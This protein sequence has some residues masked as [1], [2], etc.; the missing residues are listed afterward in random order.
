M[1]RRLLLI[2]VCCVTGEPA[3]AESAPTPN[4]AG[5]AGWN[6]AYVGLNYGIGWGRSHWKK[7]TGALT[8]SGM[9]DFPAD[10][11][12]A[13]VL[14]GLTL[15]YNLQVGDSWVI[16]VEGDVDAATLNGDADCGNATRGYGW[17]CRSGI[18]A[19]AA[20]N[21]RIGFSFGPSLLFL[22]G[23]L[24]YARENVSVFAFNPMA[25]TSP[26]PSVGAARNRFGGT[27]GVGI[28][29]A[30]GDDVSLKLE[31]DH[32]RFGSRS[33]SGVDPSWG[34]GY[35]ASADTNISTVRVG[36]NY[37]FGSHPDPS[38][39]S[40]TLDDDISGE[41]GA[42]IGW[43][44]GDYRYD[45][46][47][48]IQ[49]SR[50]NSR[51]TWPGSGVSTEVFARLDHASGAYLKGF[52]GGLLLPDGAKMFDEDFL[53]EPEEYSNTAI[54]R[55]DGGGVYAT[56]DA[57]YAFR[58]EAWRVGPFAG[59]GYFEENQRGYGCTQ[60]A[61]NSSICSRPEETPQMVAGDQLIL[62]RRA[63]WNSLR[64]GVAGDVMLTDRLRF[65]AEAAWV[66]LTSIDG[67]MDNHWARPDINPLREKRGV[68]DG[69]QLE[70]TLSYF[71]TDRV[72][73]G[74]G[75]RR[76]HM[77][78]RGS[79]RFPDVPPSPIHVVTDR[80]MVFGQIAYRFGKAG[81][82]RGDD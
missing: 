49:N 58:G 53:P 73:V 71:L 29:R 17:V 13:G 25:Y 11:E 59:Y 39:S 42:R 9:S 10:G 76:W 28:E 75:A 48:E 20:L 55:K 40:F 74:F 3:F 81:A 60:V 2:A 4:A 56:I 21:A 66:P 33:L 51:L 24:A 43:A 38:E 14:S 63:V 44:S 69:F 30:M 72:S 1:W 36:L 32:Y 27:V 23:G 54:I 62:S 70:A 15:G 41:F 80:T 8:A 77:S 45:L 47:D 52:V 16:G 6:G 19:T 31:F 35:G 67:S 79:T 7:P 61:N 12:G 50:L 5:T 37:H 57:G 68:G 64:L 78:A 26:N 18:D 82:R 34:D 46:Y 22:K 65:S